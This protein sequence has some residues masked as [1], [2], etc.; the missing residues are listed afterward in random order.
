MPK[1]LSIDKAVDTHLKPVKDSDGILTALE[2]STDKARVKSLEISGVATGQTPTTSGELATKG[3]V[4][5]N[6]GGTSYWIQQW[7]A[8]WYTRYD[9]WYFPSNTYGA[10]YQ[11]WNTTLSSSTLPSAWY[12]SYNPQIVVPK[13]C[14]ITEYKMQGS[15]NSAQTYELALM[16]GTGVTFGT[17][18]NYEMSQIGETQEQVVGTANIWYEMGQDGLSVSLSQGDTLLPCMRRSTTDT[19]TYYYNKMS[20]S[21]VCEIS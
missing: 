2:L 18:D 1:T 16:K 4:D 17:A 10:M 14:T 13:D 15:F 7:N 20:F 19:S 5:D 6:A 9:N 3:Y 12:D 11:N 8:R 21:I